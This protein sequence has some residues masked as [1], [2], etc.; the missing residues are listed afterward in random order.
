MYDF[1]VKEGLSIYDKPYNEYLPE[2][3]DILMNPQGDR[4]CDNGQCNLASHFYSG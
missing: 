3:W 1:H 4:T 2:D